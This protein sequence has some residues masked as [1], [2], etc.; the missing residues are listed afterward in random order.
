MILPDIE[1]TCTELGER[2]ATYLE[3]NNLEQPLLVGIRT[4]GV[5]VADRLQQKLQT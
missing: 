5:W 3:Q 4:G 1:Q 2:L